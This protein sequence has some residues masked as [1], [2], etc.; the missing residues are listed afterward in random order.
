MRERANA[1]FCRFTTKFMY[2][3]NMYKILIV[4]DEINIRDELATFLQT[5]G[6]DVQTV[7]DFCDVS[8]QILDS[9]VHLILL[10][11]NLPGIDG[12]H[13]AKEVRKQ[14]N[15]PMII[16]TSR[17]TD[18]DELMSMH[19][20]ADDFVSKPYNLQILLAR[21]ERLLN[22][23]YEGDNGSKLFVAG[24]QL[25]VAKSTLTYNKQSIEL[26]KNELRIMT[27]LFKHKNRIVLRE[28][29]MSEM[30]DS[31][32][33]VDDN[34]LTVNMNRLRKKLAYIDL[35]NFIETKRGMGYLINE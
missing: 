13:I 15:V 19:M 28:E 20:G 30:W 4:E 25:D 1:R 12:N 8:K 11:L 7:V 32:M 6:Y 3:K 35:E 33:F 5:N 22:R 21:M 26:T 24:V 23:S 10:D 34:A 17:N 18:L 14:S 31:D 9:D 27:T 29:L 2:N 16:V